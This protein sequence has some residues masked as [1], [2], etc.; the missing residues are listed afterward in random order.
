MVRATH[1][2]MTTV[3]WTLDCQGAGVTSMVRGYLSPW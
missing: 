2:P 1:W 3:R